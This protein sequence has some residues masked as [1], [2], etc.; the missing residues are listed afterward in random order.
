MMRASAIDPRLGPSANN[1]TFGIAP[2]AYRRHLD[3]R[4]CPHRRLLRTGTRPVLHP[5]SE[6]VSGRG[7]ARPTATDVAVTA[8]PM[9]DGSTLDVLPY[10]RS[11]DDRPPNAGVTLI[12]HY[13]GVTAL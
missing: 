10:A 5:T 2:R 7:T 6:L 8:V 9:S 4:P 11:P 1:R 3:N 13:G 12:P